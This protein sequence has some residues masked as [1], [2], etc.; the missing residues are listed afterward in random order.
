MQMN[1]YPDG[2]RLLAD[3]GG[4]NARFA[5]ELA[6]GTIQAVQT[7]ACADHARFEDAVRCYLAG[8][9]AKVSHAVIA[10]AN[11]VDGDAIRMTNHHWAF[12]I[13]AARRALGLETLLVVNDFTALAMSLP[14]L[15]PG[16]LAQVGGGAPLDGAAIGLVGAG[17]GLGVSGLVASGERWIPLNSEGG[18][19]A[20]SPLDEREVTVLRHAWQRYDHVSAERFVSGPGLVLIREALAMSRGM[21]PDK[22]LSPSDIVTRGLSGGDALSL[23]AI[24]CFCGML[25]TVAANLAVTL[26]ARGGIYIGG[27]VVPR[28]GAYFVASPF[29]PRF[30]RKGRFSEFTARIPTWLITA[31]YPALQG[32]SAI[33]SDHLAWTRATAPHMNTEAAHA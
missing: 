30:E 22:D 20:F 21:A 5:L 1:T 13:E 6:P 12:S 9:N 28:L 29:R 3:I 7:L 10:I 17:T 31:P 11:P 16:D 4:T 18:H 23:E 19:V 32:A 27:G 25:G 33:L 24:D 15:R 26:G 8:A 14:A 2:P